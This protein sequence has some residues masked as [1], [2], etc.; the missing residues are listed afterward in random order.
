VL[1]N[2]GPNRRQDTMGSTSPLAS[3]AMHL[4][5]LLD[6][7]LCTYQLPP[8]RQM[9]LHHCPQ[10]LPLPRVFPASQKG[11]SPGA[12]QSPHLPTPL[13]THRIGLDPLCHRDGR[14]TEKD[15]LWSADALSCCP[16][17]PSTSL[18]KH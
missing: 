15:W 8:H 17:E 2:L 10:V 14:V 16:A 3:D 6:L 7:P 4:L 5:G 12:S 1:A 11:G 9:S 18:Q 13:Q